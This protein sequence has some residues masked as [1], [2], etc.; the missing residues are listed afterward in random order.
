MCSWTSFIPFS[1]FYSFLRNLTA[2]PTAA[3]CSYSST[4]LLC[5]AQKCNPIFCIFSLFC[6][7]PRTPIHTNATNPDGCLQ[8]GL[9]ALIFSIQRCA[10]SKMQENISKDVSSNQSKA[11]VTYALFHAMHCNVFS[12]I[13]MIISFRL[14]LRKLVASFG[15]Y[16]E[17]SAVGVIS[18]QK[19][20]G[21]KQ[22]R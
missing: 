10:A 16:T 11:L 13:L 12:S 21:S 22:K 14:D 1:F 15:S 5:A 20:Y 7:M 3:V 8:D 17:V 19:I 4:A 6:A 18:C 2:K 9:I